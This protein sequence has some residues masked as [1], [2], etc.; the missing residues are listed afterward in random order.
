MKSVQERFPEVFALVEKDHEGMQEGH[1][2]HHV[3]RVT[4]YG[5]VIY[6]A[7]WEN[8]RDAQ[9]TEL[10]CLLHNADRVLEKRLGKKDVTTE[11][12]TDLLNKWLDRSTTK[13][14]E[15]EVIVDAVLKHNGRNDPNHSSVAMALRDADRVVNLELDLVIRSGQRFHDKPPVDYTCFFKNP[16]SFKNP[17]TV[18]EDLA[19]S[20]EWVDPKNPF[21]MQTKKGM[22]LGLERAK[23]L[24]WFFDTLKAQLHE[25]GYFS[26]K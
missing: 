5:R 20:L 1:D 2:I 17:E 13:F 19:L 16:P 15:R 3:M 12:I 23:H 8:E 26:A 10:A 14:G 18:M 25:S 9:L 24:Q 7:E 21:C 22:E 6:M 11:A 4:H